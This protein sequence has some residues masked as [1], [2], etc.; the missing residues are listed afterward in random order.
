MIG[1]KSLYNFTAHY[2]KTNS[3]IMET[4]HSNQKASL[5]T[6]ENALDYLRDKYEVLDIEYFSPIY[7]RTRKHLDKCIILRLA[8]GEAINMSIRTRQVY[9]DASEWI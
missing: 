9:I 3:Y 8:D 6:F 7:K 4:F 1:Q 5:K 2:S